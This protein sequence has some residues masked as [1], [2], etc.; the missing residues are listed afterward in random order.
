MV[1]Y[2]RGGRRRY[3]LVLLLL[4]AITL[5]TLD[6][7]SGDSGPLGAVGRAAHEVV[8]PVAK[9]V[10]AVTDPVG[11]WFEGVTSAGSLKRDNDRLRAELA[12]AESRARRGDAALQE[13]RRYKELLELEI[14]EDSEAVAAN[15]VLGPAGNY[16][17]T[18]IIDKGSDAGVG[19][20]CRSSPPRGSSGASSRSG[21]VARRCSS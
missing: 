20:G 15:V 17:S 8:S 1:V 3:V 7:R 16:E 5:I 2:R 9:A 13:N 10:N 21:R 6:K 14:P 11:D 19:E 4:T 12:D 18:I